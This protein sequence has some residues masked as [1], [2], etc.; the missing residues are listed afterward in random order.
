MK[1]AKANE[2][3]SEIPI[4]KSAKRHLRNGRRANKSWGRAV[5]LALNELVRCHNYC[6]AQQA[7]I[8]AVLRE[9]EAAFE[10]L[11]SLN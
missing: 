8:E 5:R 9:A 2:I 1:K 7:R 4:G 10:E 11:Q 6:F 3:G